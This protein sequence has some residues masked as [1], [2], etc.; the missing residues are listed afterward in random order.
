MLWKTHIYHSQCPSEHHCLVEVLLYSMVC[1]FLSF[2]L[3]DVTVFIYVSLK[4]CIYEYVTVVF[5]H[6]KLSL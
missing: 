3:T 4:D 5:T 2:H 6:G 1:L